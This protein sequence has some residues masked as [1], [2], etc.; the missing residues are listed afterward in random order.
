MNI[1]AGFSN[2]E[3]YKKLHGGEFY[4]LYIDFSTEQCRSNLSWTEA[5]YSLINLSYLS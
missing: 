1:T 3:I 4:I 2:I 5:S